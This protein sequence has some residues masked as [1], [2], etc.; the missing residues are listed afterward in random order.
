MPTNDRPNILLFLTDDHAQW[1]SR[2]YGHPTIPTPNIEYLASR[3][4]RFTNAFTPSP[5]CSPARACLFTG[6]LPSQHGIHDWLEDLGP[7]NR[8]PALQGQTTLPQMLQ[9]HGYHTGLIG[10]W[11]CDVGTSPAPGFDRWFSY[12]ADQFPHRGPQ[13]FSDDGKL[14]EEDGHQSPLLTDRAVAFLGARPLDR[15]FFL[16][17]GYVDTHSP[18]ADHPQR[19]VDAASKAGSCI[20]EEAF[21]SAHGEP[22]LRIPS[23]PGEHQHRQAEHSAG[24]RMVDEQVGR[25][26]DALDSQRLLDETL[27]IY[28]ADHGLMC[29]QH[30]T[31]GKG[32]GT[33]PQNFLDESIRV[34]LVM[35]L[36][37][38]AASRGRDCTL[39][40]DH[41]DLF[42][43]VL[44]AA[45]IDIDESTRETLRLPGKSVMP[46]IRN[47]SQPPWRDAQYCEY[48]N[49]RMIR[50]PQFKYIERNAA[51]GRRYDNEL[52]ELVIDPR[53]TTNLVAKPEYTE[54][55]AALSRDLHAYFGR[56][57]EPARDGWD[58]ER[59]PRCNNDMPWLRG[60]ELSATKEER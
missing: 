27:I 38:E 19:L 37:G 43:T 34:P 13:R 18:W 32:N 16:V 58:I 56:H 53:E 28:T 50:T 15:P 48:G 47:E 12:W 25:V 36:P 60:L 29:G 44:D 49:A 6:R 39:L 54:V 26:L 59:Q 1:A 23:D 35:S 24:V 9:S 30:G 55:I 41:C 22:F 51:Y 11:H 8:H 46:E 4:V 45:G 52:Y 2:C 20:P 14:V 42:T 3:G 57:T 31:Y 5:V 33:T 21:S 7:L 10:K 40:V 17:I